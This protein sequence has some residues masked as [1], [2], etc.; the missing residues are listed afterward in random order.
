MINRHLKIGAVALSV[1]SSNLIYSQTSTVINGRSDEDGPNLNTI[2]T[3]V[4]FLL[5]T[6]DSRGGAMGDAGV[7][8]T[9]DVYSMHWNPS[10]MAFLEEEAGASLSFT[11]WLRNIADDIYMGYLSGYMKVDDQQTIG[12]SM[13]YFS[14]GTINFTD[15][16]NNP[17]GDASPNE[18][19]FDVAYARKLSD[20]FSGAVSLRYIQSNLTRNVPLQGTGQTTPG[21]AVAADVSGYFKSNEFD[22]GGNTS[23]ASAGLNI[24]NIGSKMSYTSTKERDFLPTN[25]KLGTA[26][27]MELDEFNTFG[28][29]LDF[30]KLLVP[31]APL[32]FTD[33]TIASGEEDNVGVASGIFQSFSDA[34][35]YGV[36]DEND[37][38]LSIEKGSKFKEELREVNVSLGI[39]Y[40]Y[41]QKFAVRAGY[42]NEHFTKGNRKY[43][44]MGAGMRFSKFELDLSYLVSLTQQSPLAN[45]IRV[46][47]QFHFNEPAKADS[48]I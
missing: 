35:G 18:F 9:A 36:Y 26:L 31:T 34:P 28:F 27:N 48:S 45:T 42:F 23:F 39:E 13:R 2:T 16:N 24:S 14:L 25:M 40:W 19:A 20:N 12:A 43:A 5:I 33:G 6:P 32:R 1:L 47:M 4:P 46:S 11:P 10:K 29:M 22:L 7:A 3:A 21:R 37:N 30:N 17:L 38:L 15:I 8:S 44:T 41:A